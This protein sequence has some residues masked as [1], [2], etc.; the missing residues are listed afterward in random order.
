MDQIQASVNNTMSIFLKSKPKHCSP[1]PFLHKLRLI[2]SPAEINLMS[3]SCEIVS[4][5]F[6]ETITN[7]FPGI[8]IIVNF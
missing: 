5:A 2:K 8:L 3:K 1:K 7:S 6:T 4:E